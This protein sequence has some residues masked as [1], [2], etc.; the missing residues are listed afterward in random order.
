MKEKKAC[1]KGTEIIFNKIIE[2]HF[3]KLKKKLPV[4][5]QDTYRTTKRRKQ[6]RNTS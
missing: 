6:K 3:S 1:F 5:V 4:K 2:E